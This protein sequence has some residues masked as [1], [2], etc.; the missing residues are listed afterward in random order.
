MF[1]GVNIHASQFSLPI[2]RCS[3]HAQKTASKHR[4]ALAG[5]L[6]P[7]LS[8]QEVINEWVQAAVKTRHAKRNG[9]KPFDGQSK[10]T[11]CNKALGYHQI[12]QK[13]DVVGGETETE[14]SCA[15]PDHVQGLLIVT[16]GLLA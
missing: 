4:Y 3:F 1:C 14:D 10:F 6:L 16:C 12:E 7:E 9:M 13:V 11:V 8:S 5:N 15:D 2:G